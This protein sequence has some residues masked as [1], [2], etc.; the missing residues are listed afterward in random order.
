MVYAPGTDIFLN[1]WINRPHDTFNKN[2]K[3]LSLQLV[4]VEENGEPH[5]VQVSGQ[6]SYLLSW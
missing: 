2:V 3:S 4:M 6:D 1:R 5:E